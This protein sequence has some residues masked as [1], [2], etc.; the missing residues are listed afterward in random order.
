[1]ISKKEWKEKKE[2]IV[3]LKKQAE[4]NLNKATQD[5]EELTFMISA[6]NKKIE[7]FK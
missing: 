5:I 6:M 4:F 7:T 1:M 3:K 2:G